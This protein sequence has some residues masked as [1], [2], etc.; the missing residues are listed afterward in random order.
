MNSLPLIVQK[1]SFLTMNPPGDRGK[2]RRDVLVYA[3][4]I[5]AVV[6][7]WRAIWDL[8]TEIMSPWTSLAVGLAL[9]GAI[10]YVR[11]D[12]IERLF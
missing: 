4:G 12:F 2:K 9:V 7:I 8:A 3:L 11:R 6:L 10:A 5:V 1:L